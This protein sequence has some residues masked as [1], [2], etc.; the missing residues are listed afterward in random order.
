MTLTEENR[1]RAGVQSVD[2]A[3]RIL[4]TLA[5]NPFPI[6]VADLANRVQLSTTSVHRMLTTLAALGWVEQ[7]T[8]TSRYRLGTRFLGAGAAGLITHP[9]VQHGRY[10]L[11]RLSEITGYDTFLSTLV[12][13]RVVYLAK[14]DGEQGLGNA[15]EPG[16]SLP[17][18]SMA[19]G[20]LLLA[21]TSREAREELYKLGLEPY[22]KGTITDPGE[23]EAELATILAQGY[24]LDRGERFDYSRAMAVPVLGSDSQPLIGMSCVGPAEKM[25]LTDEYV[26]WL[27]QV[28]R[29][30][31]LEMADHLTIHGDLPKVNTDAARHN[32]W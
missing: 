23:L 25:E 13:G 16:V 32:L 17:A 20:K 3:V 18:H 30:L 22:A 8:R 31:A 27:S 24:A 1:S 19:T 26:G 28:M 10:F 6:G 4:T 7:N 29:S 21:Y 11:D 9:L 5:G 14:C 2:R 12:A 15:F